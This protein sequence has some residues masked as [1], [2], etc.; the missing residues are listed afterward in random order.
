ME[1][2]ENTD[3]RD[4]RSRADRDTPQ[5]VKVAAIVTLVIVAMVVVMLIV[6]GDHGPGRH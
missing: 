1:G 3:M 4:G 2:D 6:G 5:W